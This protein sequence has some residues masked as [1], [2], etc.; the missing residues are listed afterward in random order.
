MWRHREKTLGH[1]RKRPLKECDPAVTLLSNLKPPELEENKFLLFKLLVCGTWILAKQTNAGI[2]IG[3]C[4]Y[5]YVKICYCNELYLIWY[6]LLFAQWH[7][8]SCS[9]FSFEKLQSIT[10]V[11]LSGKMWYE[12]NN[13]FFNHQMLNSCFDE[14]KQQADDISTLYQG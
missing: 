6:Y 2:K 13:K 9:V 10:T 4:S 7:A 14:E 1:S 12:N 5:K 3:Y 8:F 11:L